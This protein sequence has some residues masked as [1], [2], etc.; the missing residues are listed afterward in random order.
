MNR[1]INEA[2]GD[3]IYFLDSDDFVLRGRTS[4][5]MAKLESDD[6]LDCVGSNYLRWDRKK[7]FKLTEYPENDIDIKRYFWKYPCLLYSSLAMKMESYKENGLYFR[8][9]LKGGIDYEFYSRLLASCKV[10]NINRP[11][12]VYTHSKDSITSSET[13]RTT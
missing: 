1:L 6:S 7:S 8:D 4:Q 10:A 2:D 5:Q 11:L 3:V 12:V 9:D 13:H